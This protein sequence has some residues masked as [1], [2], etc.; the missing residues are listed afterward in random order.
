MHIGVLCPLAELEQISEHI[1]QQDLFVHGGDADDVF[2][3]YETF[4][5]SLYPDMLMRITG[6]CPYWSP[7]LAY[8]LLQEMV[9]K[10]ADFGWIRT[11]NDFPDGLDVE[12][13]RRD[14]FDRMTAA[15]RHMGI[16]EHVTIGLKGSWEIQ[17]KKVLI[18]PKDDSYNLPY[19]LSIDTEF[20]LNL[21]KSK[22]GELWW[23]QPNTR[24]D[25]KKS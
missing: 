22:R 23:I 4:H 15:P 21:I 24:P 1:K 11:P 5:T 2:A 14:L 19:K 13:I 20:D 18:L 6:D 9:L 3:R 25:F 7:R 17:P 16:A 8:R 10:D 12:I